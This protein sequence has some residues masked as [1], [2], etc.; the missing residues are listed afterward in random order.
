MSNVIVDSCVVAKWVLAEPDSAK[1]RQLGADTTTSGHKS[2]ALDLVYAEVG[3]A[4]WKR[5]YRGIIDLQTTAR[6]LTDLD[7]SPL[8]IH[9]SRRL[10]AP[11]MMVASKYRRSFYDSLFVA[12]V[13]DLQL[14]GVTADEP[15][16]RAVHSDHPG[17]VPLRDW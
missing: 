9:S 5:H 2:L 10:L 7:S 13:A 15:L 17:I 16:Y 1:A 6:C 11:A 8:D 14:P 3:N 12:H 4:I